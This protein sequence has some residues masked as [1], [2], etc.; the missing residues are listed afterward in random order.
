M[1]IAAALMIF[2]L[3]WPAA[4][5]ADA[6]AG[7]AEFDRQCS[8]CHAIQ[9]Q[10]GRILVGRTALTGPNLFAVPGRRLGTLTS[11]RYSEA[12]SAAGAK[13]LIWTEEAFVGYLQD[14]T[15]WLRREMGDNRLRSRMVY[16]VRSRQEAADIYAYLASLSA[17]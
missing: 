6:A 3:S 1:R 10:D 4:V 14:P 17:E 15:G 2:A 5:V 7:A 11:F 13:G 8:A 12:L 9:R 16:R